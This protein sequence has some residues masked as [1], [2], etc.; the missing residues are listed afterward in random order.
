MKKLPRKIKIASLSSYSILFVFFFSFSLVF[1]LALFS[2]KAHA[3]ITTGLVGHWTLDEGTSTTANDTSGNNNTGTLINNPS[4]VTGH[5]GNGALNFDGSTKYVEATNSPS[6]SISGNQLTVSAWVFQPNNIS[7]STHYAIIAKLSD[8]INYISPYFSYALYF[9]NGSYATFFVTVGGSEQ[10]LTGP[11]LSVNAWHHI[12]G[13]YDGSHILLYT[14]GVLQGTQAQTG[15][16]SAFSTPFRIGTNTDFSRNYSGSI[17][18]VRIYNRAL[19]SSDVT[20]LYDITPPVLSSIAS[21]TATSFAT[22]TWTTDEVSDSQVDYG[23][24]SSY[25]SSSTLNSATTTTHSVTL[26]SLS[27]GT[28]YHFRVRSTDESGNL[29]TSSDK[30]FTIPDTTPPTVTFTSPANGATVS[31]TSVTLTATS[32]DNVAVT[33]VQ[34]N[35]DGTNTGSSGTTSPYSIIWDSTSVSDGSH[36]LKAVAHDAALN[37][38]TSTI[39]VTVD[40]R[41]PHPRLHPRRRGH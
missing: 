18:E 32:T 40:N 41:N 26:S 20:Q 2:E 34:F 4:W 27:S 11:S 30:T 14:D 10:T 31:G 33:G 1:S 37:Y 23:L 5:V 13:V 7:T 22:I 28:T 29:A 21:T 39:T 36:T 38:A 25:T 17:D 35:L 15:N 24:T 9:L 16:I 8:P 12:V 6:L 19:S 3:D